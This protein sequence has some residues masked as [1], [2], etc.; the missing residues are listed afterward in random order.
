MTRWLVFS[1]S[2]LQARVSTALEV[3]GIEAHVVGVESE[4]DI[5]LLVASEA[6]QGGRHF[7]AVGDDGAVGSV[8][9]A[10]MSL[11][12]DMKPVLGI[13]PG[14]NGND[15]VRTFGFPQ[16]L[17][18]AVVHLGGSDTYDCDIGYLEG[19]WGHRYFINAATA[20][21]IGPLEGAPRTDFE[22]V[23]EKRTYQGRATGVLIANGQFVE[24]GMR[25]APRATVTDAVLDVQM[26]DVRR[27]DQA[28]FL[29]IVA[30]GGHLKDRRVRRASVETFE[31][32]TRKPWPVSADGIVIGASPLRG[33]SVPGAVSIKI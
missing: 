9:D 16:S 11:T 12:W 7:V 18:E 28:E 27:H 6:E 1:P 2:T 31:L 14:D 23:T 21:R 20:G 17:E 26:W 8:V 30:T 25:A 33:R 4:S 3:A 29:R 15:F 5:A 13:L 24:M 32:D 10:L 19:E 22:L